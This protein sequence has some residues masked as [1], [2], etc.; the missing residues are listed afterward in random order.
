[1]KKF[2]SILVAM[3]ILFSFS[4]VMADSYKNKTYKFDAVGTTATFTL[5]GEYKK[6]YDYQFRD[7]GK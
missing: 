1:M 4:T 2:A 3:S 7:S 5:D 6:L